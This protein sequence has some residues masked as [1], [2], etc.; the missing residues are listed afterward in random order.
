V[1]GEW[2]D[3]FRRPLGGGYERIGG[4]PVRGGADVGAH[5]YT[6]VIPDAI[7]LADTSALR[8]R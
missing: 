7:S 6:H 5:K 2:V 8:G 3:S 1:R 4:Q